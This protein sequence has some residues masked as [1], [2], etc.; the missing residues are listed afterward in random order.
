MTRG[1]TSGLGSAARPQF[2]ED[3]IGRNAW[4]A[5][6]TGLDRFPQRFEIAPLRIAV[7]RPVSQRLAD[8]LA[9]GD[10]FPARYGL[11]QGLGQFG[12]HCDRHAFNGSHG[13]SLSIGI[14][15]HTYDVIK[16][17]ALAGVDEID[18]AK[19]I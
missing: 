3:L 6:E 18:G 7:S 15:K 1:G 17:F 2:C 19:A 14:L 13:G 8:N 16:A 4:P 5:V 12:R 11:T 10:V 9:G